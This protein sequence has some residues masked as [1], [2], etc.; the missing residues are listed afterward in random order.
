MTPPLGSTEPMAWFGGRAATGLVEVRHAQDAAGALAVLDDLERVGGWWA[1]VAEYEGGLTA[2]RFREVRAA[3]L[4]AAATPWTG[5]EGAWTSSM[6]R[7]AYV[8]ACVEVRRR[9]GRGEVYQVNICRVVEHDLVPDDDLLALAGALQ[10]ANPA[11]Y[12]GFVR[13]PGTQVVCA[14]PELFLSRSGDQVVTG[15]IKGTAATAA[16]LL[17]KDV[18]ENVMIVDLARNDLSTVCEPGSVHVPELLVTE[19]HP[20]LVHLVS[21]VQ[22]TLRPGLGWAALWAAT[23]PPASVTGAPKST[24]LLAIRELEP[25]ARGPYCGPIGWVDV[26]ARQA[27]LAV[28]I[29]T[30]WSQSAPGGRRVLRFGTGAGITWGSDPVGEWQETELKAR[31]L[32]G[33]AGAA[34]PL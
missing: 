27:R 13:L 20:G 10:R 7:D 24:A 14:S 23:T 32:L 15:P 22:G 9:I 3:P 26:D 1:V 30:F 29:R 19:V 6:S 4:P 33:V 11:P 5:L 12:A 28:G 8:A 34:A 16:G 18:D 2:A 17:A 21:R 25:T 31:R